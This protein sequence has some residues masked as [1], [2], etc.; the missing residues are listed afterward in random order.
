MHSIMSQHAQHDAI[1]KA[2]HDA[3]WQATCA[4]DAGALRSTFEL[5]RECSRTGFGDQKE[6]LLV[7]MIIGVCVQRDEQSR[8]L[9]FLLSDRAGTG[10][11]EGPHLILVII[12]VCVQRDE[13]A[14]ILLPKSRCFPNHCFRIKKGTVIERRTSSSSSLESVRNGTSSLRVRSSP[15]AIAIVVSRLTE[16]SRSVMSSF[17]SSSLRK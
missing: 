10:H 4:F 17:L 2:Q 15:S 3:A 8:C 14:D 12:G 13:L 7:F 6:R 16:F 9:W 5:S 1:H 11:Q